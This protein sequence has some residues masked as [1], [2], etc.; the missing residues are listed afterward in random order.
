[1]SGHPP[2]RHF[3]SQFQRF[4]AIRG[5]VNWEWILEIDIAMIL[6]EELNPALPVAIA[7]ENFL[8][9]QKGTALLNVL[10][11]R[12]ER[13][14]WQSHRIS[15]SKPGPN[16]KDHPPWR[17][18][19]DGRN[20]MRSHRGNPIA[21]NRDTGCKFDGFC[22]LRRQRHANVDIAIDHLRV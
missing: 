5:K 18:Q 21:G 10:A 22:M 1:Q 3:P 9:A 13:Y 11:V 14:R 7:I 4:G 19:I 16:A 6:M 8:P 17:E 12:F 15:T 20:R 2:I